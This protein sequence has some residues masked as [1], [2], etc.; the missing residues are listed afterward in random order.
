MVLESQAV[1]M[2]LHSRIK[3]FRSCMQVSV[4]QKRTSQPTTSRGWADQIMKG[5]RIILRSL[6]NSSTQ[7]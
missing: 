5:I 4:S 2:I 7:R 1:S 6:C 3:Q